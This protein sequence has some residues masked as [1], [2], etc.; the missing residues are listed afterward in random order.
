L[1][2]PHDTVI[3]EGGASLGEAGVAE[4]ALGVLPERAAA[5]DTTLLLP[6]VAEKRFA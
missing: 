6:H 3:A 4:S 1:G 2:S 5:P